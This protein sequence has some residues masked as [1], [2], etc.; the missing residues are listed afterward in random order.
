MGEQRAAATRA[1]DSSS[2]DLRRFLRFRTSDGDRLVRLREVVEC[3]PMVRIEAQRRQGDPR[4]RGLLHFRGRVVPVF[5]P[6]SEAREALDPDWF[7]L[8]VQADGREIALVARDFYDIVT[9]PAEQC[10]RIAVG[11]GAEV[12]V[13]SSEEEVLRVVEPTR[14]LEG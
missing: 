1:P 5:E 3:I 7:L 2:S 10:R 13:V 8:V 12:A 9:S 4:Y 6:V 14:L 11:G